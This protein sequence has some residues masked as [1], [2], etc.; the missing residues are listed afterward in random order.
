MSEAI[1]N[2]IIGAAATIIAAVVGKISSITV[3]SFFFRSRKNIPQI[4][5]TVWSAQWFY[6]DGSLYVKDRITFKKWKKNNEFTGYG[7]MEKG[8][9]VYKYPIKGTVAPNGIVV[10]YYEAEEFPAQGNIGMAC[11]ELSINAL[12]LVGSWAGRCSKKL[13]DGNW[14]N[15]IRGGKVKMERRD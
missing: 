3:F 8:K 10:L 6:E 11:L 4:M 12:E 7:E 1:I 2:A 5:K 14:V 15:L 13:D 9:K